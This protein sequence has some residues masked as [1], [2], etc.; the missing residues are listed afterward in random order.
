M[1]IPDSILSKEAQF[2]Y[3][4]SYGFQPKDGDLT[5]WR[6]FI[7]VRIEEGEYAIDVEIQLLDSFPASAPLIH[8]MTPI[9]HPN[10]DKNGLL[11]MRMLARWRSSYHLFQV[12]VE[13][14][15]LFSKVPPRMK[16]VEYDWVDPQTQFNSLSQ[17]KNQLAL[18]LK[19]KRSTLMEMKSRKV[20]KP[21]TQVL[22]Q[23]KLNHL[24]DEIL[25]LESQLF[26][27]EQQFE[28]YDMLSLEFAKKY[29]SLKKRVYLLQSQK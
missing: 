21:S 1:S 20:S 10:V 15:R 17:Q 23:E 5:R 6:G 29:Y 22:E 24:D 27:I 14:R 7:P 9:S 4:R 25:G 26:A 13:I 11:D 19:Q 28:D 2:V 16:S 8:V 18:I 3:E 12:I